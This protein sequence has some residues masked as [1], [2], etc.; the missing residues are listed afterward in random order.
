MS[1]SGYR[2]LAVQS[3]LA[4]A[5]FVILVSLGVWQVQRL[6]WKE[7]L[8]ARVENRLKAEPV[9]APG[10]QAWPTLDIAAAEYEPVTVTGHYLNDKEA[11]VVFSLTEPRGP[12]GGIGYMV[13][14]PFETGDGWIVYVNRGFVPQDR[15]DPASRA[16]G[17][18]DGTTTATGLLREASRAA[19]F[20][21]ADNP[22]RNEW[23][24]RDPAAFAAASGLPA[25]KVAPYIIDA[26]FDP[27][28]PG[29][30]PQGG[31]TLVSFPN[32][33]LQYAITWFGLAIALA[34]IFT[35]FA[36]RQ[37]KR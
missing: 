33:H 37:R 19:W 26:A 12:V 30:L 29:G 23:F 27:N 31:E 34:V 4:A 16:E 1:K 20:S 32:N 24:S 17:I 9:A 35:T 5:G 14:T 25:E 28:L 15:E 3:I 6:H 2:R 13:M 21:P 18:V 22:A 10:P 8:I 7:A 11:H 36:L